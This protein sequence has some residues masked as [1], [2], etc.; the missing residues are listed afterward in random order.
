MT[1]KKN[2]GTWIDTDTGK[3]VTSRPERGVQLVSPDVEPT[4]DDL[5][6]VDAAKAAAAGEDDTDKT[7]TSKTAK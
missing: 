1:E 7:V 5:A 6:A 3:V 4:P 2:T